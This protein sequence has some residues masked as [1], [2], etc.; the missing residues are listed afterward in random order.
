M[1]HG[2]TVFRFAE[3]ASKSGFFNSFQ[4]VSLSL[5]ASFRQRFGKVGEQNGDPQPQTYRA[6]KPRIALHMA[7]GHC[8][9]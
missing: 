7:C 6:G 3:F 2:G 4:T 1:I 9:R 5:T 8:Q